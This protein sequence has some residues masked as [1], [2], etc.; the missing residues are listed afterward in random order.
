[1]SPSFVHVAVSR[2]ITANVAHLCGSVAS[3]SCSELWIARE[4]KRGKETYLKANSKRH[5]NYDL[6]I[7]FEWCKRKFVSFRVSKVII[8]HHLSTPQSF[9]DTY[10]IFFDCSYLSP[11]VNI[12]IMSITRS[13]N[14]KFNIF[15]EINRL[16]FFTQQM[17]TTYKSRV[18]CIKYASHV[19]VLHSLSLWTKWNQRLPS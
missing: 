13:L 17:L 1:M 11:P 12:L 16:S 15:I 5:L 18:P 19:F 6:A 3:P 7:I 10:H 2:E 9:P 14:W 4:R 8:I